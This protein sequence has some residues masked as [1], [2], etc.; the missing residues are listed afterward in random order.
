MRLLSEGVTAPLFTAPLKTGELVRLADYRGKKNVVLFFYPR[1]FT[2]GCTREV[3]AYGD[4]YADIERYDAVIFGVSFDS[5]T[6]HDRF[7]ER[8]NIPFPL[9]TDADRAISRAYGVARMNGMFP[10]VKRVTFVI[11]KAGVIRKV[12]HREMDIDLHVEDALG[13]LKALPSA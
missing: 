3:C 7:T 2:P 8:Y 1:D 13:A 5:A 9:L 12:I 6:S 4:S 10:L 11:D